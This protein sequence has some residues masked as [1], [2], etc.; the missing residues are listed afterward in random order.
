MA[1]NQNINKVSLRILVDKFLGLAGRDKVSFTILV[2]KF[3][4]D[5]FLVDKF[6]GP[7]KFPPARF[8]RR[9]GSLKNSAFAARRASRAGSIPSRILPLRQGPHRKIPP[10]R[11]AR[12][13]DSLKDFAFVTRSALQ[14][15]PGA[16][17]APA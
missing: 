13:V 3:L 4:V 8:A 14:I 9:V 2:D 12:R 1:G 11:F 5:K 16:L 6:L 15:P 10:A 7:R 17:R